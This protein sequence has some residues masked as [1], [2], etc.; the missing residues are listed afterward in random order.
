MSNL[1]ERLMKADTK[2]VDQKITGTFKSKMLARALGESEPVEIT[3][4]EISARRQ[5]EMSQTAVDN[6]GNVDYGKAYDA[7][8]KMIVAGVIDPPLKDKELQEHFGCKM[9]IDL[10][11]KLFKN[12][13]GDIA[14]AIVNLGAVGDVRTDEE[15]IKN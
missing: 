7:Q 5:G 12:E 3:I 2:N 4:Q 1:V 14:E 11:E 9:A 8:L 13:A 15:E 10:A 6:N